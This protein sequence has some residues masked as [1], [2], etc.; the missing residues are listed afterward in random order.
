MRR[1]MMEM[2]PNA[3]LRGSVRNSRILRLAVVLS[4]FLFTLPVFAQFDTGTI[5]G[6][7]TDSSGA[8]VAN[9]AVSVTNTGTGITKTLHTDSNGDFVASA[10]QFGNYVVSATASGFSESKSQQ[11]VLNVGST[12]HVK[13]TMSVAAATESVVVTGT[14]TT[15]DTTSSTSGTTLNADQV[16]NLPINGRDVSSF[17]NIAPGSINSTGFF[18]GSV[19][20]LENI[21]TGLNVTVDGQSATRGDINGF[22]A[23]EGQEAARVTRSSLDSIQEIDF[24]NSGY[25]AETGHSLGPQMNIITKAGTNDFHGTVFEF[26]RNNAMDARDYFDNGPKQQPLRL[27]QFGANIGGPII[28]NKFFFFANYEGVRQTITQ[29]KPLNETLSQN[30]RS[31]FTDTNYLDGQPNLL[32]QTLLTQLMPIPA[33]CMGDPAPVS[34]QVKDQQGNVIPQLIYAPVSLP[35]TLREDTG[36]FRL[37]YNASDSDRIFFRY[38]ISDSLTNFTFGPNLGQSSPQKLRNQ[39]GKID[40]THTFS[41]TLLNQFSV[42]A[43]RFYSDT[44]SNTVD[45]YEATTGTS[46][47]GIAGFFTNLGSLP[48][49]NTF[50]QITPFTQ[51]ELFEN[52]TKIAGSHSLRFGAQIRLNRFNEALRPQQT[53]YYAD[54]TSLLRNEPF[55]IAKNGFPGSV[56]IKNSN[57]DFYVQ[58]DWRATRKLTLNIGLRYDYNTVWRENHNQIANFD[59]DTQTILPNTQAPYNA[60]KSDFAPRLGFSF[61]PFGTGKTVI[62]GYGGLFYMPM[63]LSF[64]LTSN[65]PALASYNENELQALG[66]FGPPTFPITYPAPPPPLVAGTQNVYA[67]PRNPKDPY[68]TN[69]LFG[70]QQEVAR[71]TVLTVNYTGNKTQHMQAGVSFAAINLNPSNPFSQVRPHSQFANENYLGDVLSSNY[72]ALQ[73]Q[74]RHNLGNLQFEANYTWSHEIDDLVNVFSGFSNPYDP[75]FD[76]GSGDIDVRHNLT[77]SIVYN[78][79]ELKDRNTLVRAVLGGWQTSNILQTRSGLPVDVTLV[80]GFFGNPVRP[81]SVSGQNPLISGT[82]WP[83]KR[84]N[85]DA[86]V[87]PPGYDG[88]PGENLGDVGRNTLRGP[89]FFQWDW[90]GM[91]NF[92]ITEKAKVQFRVDLFNI[93]NHPNFSSPDGGVCTSVAHSNPFDLTSPLVCTTNENFGKVSSTVAGA[94]NGMIGNGTAR[95]A[96]LSLKVIF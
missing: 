74:L 29:I 55:V 39:L 20:G 88:T 69:W 5:A 94:S 37:D 53:Y 15:V 68:S 58:D 47:V 71:N 17:L 3:Q 93:L 1:E 30:A 52:V 28:K 81:N 91:K 18:Q 85:N 8:V 61:D 12:V 34:C 50:N 89:A 70:I 41:P 2:T 51:Y 96:Q 78:L 38:N 7:V 87:L 59:P 72:N 13:L 79:P 57:W 73:L 48:G 56:G 90:S 42:S 45:P 11:I 84:F 95:Q 9:A 66:F 14:A 75:S 10:L 35:T 32:K 63:Y 26:L 65:I 83:N 4:L 6:T 86:Y 16:S 46:L 33:G 54:F 67:F 44:N 92:A 64:N 76:R 22:L 27:N 82:S 24:S 31:N 49:P 60:P 36:S 62:H 23:T 25:T 40:Y 43:T 80:S 21:F 77:G 19:N